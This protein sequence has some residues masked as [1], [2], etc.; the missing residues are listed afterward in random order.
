[1]FKAEKGNIQIAMIGWSNEIFSIAKEMELDVKIV[2]DPSVSSSIPNEIKH[3][4][5]DTDFICETHDAKLL[6]AIDDNLVR[7]RVTAFYEQHDYDIL[8]LKSGFVS[9]TSHYGRGLICQRFSVIS[10]NCNIGNHVRLNTGA[11]VTHDVNIGSYSTIAPGAVILGRT[12][13]GNGVYV[14]ANSTI[15]GDLEIANNVTIGAGA[16]VTKNIAEGKIVAGVPAKELKR[17]NK[18]IN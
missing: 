1:M 13:I 2:V 15:L 10:D 7:E 18:N 3:Y 17:K 12:I 16:V 8:S 5:S 9:K 6:F 14:G 11:I 4:S